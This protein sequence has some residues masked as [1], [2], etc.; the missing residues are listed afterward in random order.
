MFGVVALIRLAT[1]AWNQ[2][3]IKCCM[4]MAIGVHRE[5]TE[6]RKK[7]GLA[8]ASHLATFT[9]MHEYSP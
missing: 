6:V 2:A 4:K 7:A 8:L 5:T 1:T 3:I 9:A